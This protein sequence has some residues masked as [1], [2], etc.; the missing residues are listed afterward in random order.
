MSLKISSLKKYRSKIIWGAVLAVFAGCLLRVMIWETNYY[1]EKEGSARA[2]SPSPAVVVDT[3]DVDET[4]I[5]DDQISE[6]VV[7][8]NRPRYLSIEKLGITNARVLPVGVSSSGQLLTPASIY[9]VGW[10]NGSGLPGSGGTLLMDGHNG[11]PTKIGVF[12]NLPSLVEGDII[13]L[14]RGDGAIFKYEV[15]E[16]LTVSLDQADSKMASM[17]RSAIS[18]KEGLN[19]ITCTGDWS[20]VQQTY[21]SRQFLRAV[22]VE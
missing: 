20:Q 2:T 22:R 12:K 19:L 4:E 5:T 7:A 3:S 18:G 13:T 17:E 8:A 9:D 11:G 14:E 16:N 1:N 10:Y 15:V 6:W 21:L